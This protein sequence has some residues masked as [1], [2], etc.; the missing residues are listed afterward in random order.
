MYR[1][2]RVRTQSPRPDR[3]AGVRCGL[4]KW[5]AFTQHHSQNALTQY[6]SLQFPFSFAKRGPLVSLISYPVS[7]LI[8]SNEKDMGPSDK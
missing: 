1:V 4:K 5:E 2:S 6:H 7:H 3:I 8:Q